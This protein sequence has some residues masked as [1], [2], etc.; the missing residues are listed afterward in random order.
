M[1]GKVDLISLS[2]IHRKRDQ[3]LN[4]WQNPPRLHSYLPHHYSV[5]FPFVRKLAYYLTIRRLQRHSLHLKIGR[6]RVV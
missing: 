6:E 4:M 2:F 3:I 5:P 1:L